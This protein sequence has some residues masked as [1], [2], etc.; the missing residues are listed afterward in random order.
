MRRGISALVFVAAAMSGASAMAETVTQGVNGDPHWWRIDSP[1]VNEPRTEYQQ[2]TF[3]AGDKV[4]FRAGGCVQTG[5]SGKTWKRYVNPSGP[6]SLNL[7]HGEIEIPGAIPTLTFLSDFMSPE[8]EGD[9]SGNVTVQPQNGTFPAMYLTLGYTDDGYGDNGYWGH[10]DGTEN[11][12]EN[13]GNA[14]VD[15]YIV[16]APVPVPIRRF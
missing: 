15:I 14:F 16:P 8:E 3:H 4:W 9:W 7:Y 12:C 2:I 11:Q 6:N 10:D 13:I 1:R 5:G